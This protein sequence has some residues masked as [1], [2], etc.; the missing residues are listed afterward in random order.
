LTPAG[1][2]AL[3]TPWQGVGWYRKTST[4]KGAAEQRVYCDF[5]GVMAFPRVHVNGQL[6]GDWD[7]GY[8]SFRVDATPHIRFGERNVIAVQI[9]TRRHQSRWYP[10]AG[11]YRKVTMT[12][13]G[14][15]HIA[16][17]GTLVTTPVISDG[18]ATVRVQ[19]SI[20][21]HQSAGQDVSV[22]VAV[23]ERETAMVRVDASKNA[24]APIRGSALHGSSGMYPGQ[25]SF[26][27]NPKDRVPRL[28]RLP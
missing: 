13:T 6:A 11:I 24:A 15:M 9:D 10:G 18:R 14:P 4:A 22:E 20:D 23:F 7:Y 12:L 5:D 28:R 16:R 3:E 25:R 8:I 2:A 21:N 1:P 26:T 19:A 17:W 27:Q